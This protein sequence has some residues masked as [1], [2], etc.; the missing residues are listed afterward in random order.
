[1]KR[2]HFLVYLQGVPA[3]VCSVAVT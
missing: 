3:T 2:T 1:M